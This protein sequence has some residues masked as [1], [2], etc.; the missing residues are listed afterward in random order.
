MA[1]ARVQAQRVVRMT[2][3]RRQ[4]IDDFDPCLLRG[5]PH[6]AMRLRE[7]RVGDLEGERQEQ[8]DESRAPARARRARSPR[9]GPGSAAR[10]PARGA[11]DTRRSS[12]S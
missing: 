3:E 12:T 8:Q 9:S 7:G 5:L 1:I 11:P 4:G 10:P 2:R 6:L